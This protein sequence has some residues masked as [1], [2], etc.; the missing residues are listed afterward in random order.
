MRWMSDVNHD[1]Q[2]GSGAKSV[3]LKARTMKKPMC[4][5]LLECISRARSHQCREFLLKSLNDSE[6]LY[7]SISQPLLLKIFRASDRP[8]AN[9]M[10]RQLVDSQ[11]ARAGFE[12]VCDYNGNKIFKKRN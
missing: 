4:A 5:Y 2:I 11:K 9:S 3:N 6:R 12:D 10:W 7:S 1:P 8:K